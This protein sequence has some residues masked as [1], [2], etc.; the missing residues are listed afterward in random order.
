MQTR[1]G[2]NFV[3]DKYV[4]ASTGGVGR[5][6]LSHTKGDAQLQS[7][8]VETTGRYKLGQALTMRAV[9]QLRV[10]GSLDL[11]DTVYLGCG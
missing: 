7:V 9:K 3:N 5:R 2:I 4:H 1:T 8:K 10:P 11:S 6:Q